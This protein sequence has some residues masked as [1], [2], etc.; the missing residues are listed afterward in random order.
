[1]TNLKKKT[2]PF[3]SLPPFPNIKESIPTN[4]IKNRGPIFGLFPF[5]ILK[6]VYPQIFIKTRS[7]FLLFTFFIIK[8]SILTNL[9]KS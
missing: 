9:K 3:F 7:N 6:K 8:K 4:L 1:M 2:G 5:Q